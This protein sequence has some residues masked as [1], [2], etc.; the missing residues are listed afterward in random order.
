MVLVPSFKKLYNRVFPKKAICSYNRGKYTLLK[1][2]QVVLAKML[3]HRK[4]LQKF[5]EI[6]LIM[7]L[8]NKEVEF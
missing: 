1:L 3:N 6:G 8:D 4:R 7:E 2:I 5:P